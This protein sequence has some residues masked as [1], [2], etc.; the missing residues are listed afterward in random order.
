[1]HLRLL[2]LALCLAAFAAAGCG[3]QQIDV[4]KSA[5]LIQSSVEQQVGATVKSIKCP[6]EVKVKAKAVFTCLVT[7]A[8]GTTGTA[9]VTQTDGKGTISVAA[10]FLHKDEA[11]QSIQTDLRKREPR[12]TVVCPDIIVVKVGGTFECRA[13]LG[14]INATVVVTQANGSIKYK[15]K[16]E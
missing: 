6:D 4:K 9:S 15:I 13:N 3:E 2:A 14:E 1:M 7:G 10:P 8:D 12:A 11:E 16:R 5:K